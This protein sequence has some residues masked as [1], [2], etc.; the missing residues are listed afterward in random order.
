M[1][2]LEYPT[3]VQGHPTAVLEYPIAVLEYPT[4]V[5]AHRKPL[6]VIIMCIHFM[7]PELKTS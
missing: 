4:A 5:L 6:P 2:V 7:L 1:A 3:A